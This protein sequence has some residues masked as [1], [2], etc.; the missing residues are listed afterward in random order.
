MQS[1]QLFLLLSMFVCL[2]LSRIEGPLFDLEIEH[3]VPE[4]HLKPKKPHKKPSSENIKVLDT[5]DELSVLEKF[6]LSPQFFCT[7]R[8]SHLT[9]YLRGKEIG[10]KITGFSEKEEQKSCPKQF[11]NGDLDKL[12]MI[13]HHLKDPEAAGCF[14]TMLYNVQNFENTE[15]SST[16]Y[17]FAHLSNLIK[18]I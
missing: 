15:F 16:N 17:G 4:P 3:S 9:H 12:A 1:K 5:T 13:G 2:S 6:R 14:H 11:E 7:E 10:Y 18:V 8:I